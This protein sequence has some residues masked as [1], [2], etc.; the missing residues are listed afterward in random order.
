MVKSLNLLTK[1]RACSSKGSRRNFEVWDM[2][3]TAVEFRAYSREGKG[4]RG[5][6]GEEQSSNNPSG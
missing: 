1:F 3:E 4:C 2:E 6:D 5:A